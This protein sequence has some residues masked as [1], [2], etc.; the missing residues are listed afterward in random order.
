MPVLVFHSEIDAPE[1]WRQVLARA[2]P[3]L[4]FRIW[5]D[6]GPPAEVRYALVWK[7][8]HGMLASF[9]KLKAILSLGAGV[10][11][12]FLDA[13]LPRTV[14]ILR[15]VD[16][17]LRGQMTEY[18]LYAVLYFHRDMPHY[19]A[20][21]LAGRW[22]PLAAV[23]AA[24]RTVGVMGLGVLGADLA[25]MLVALGFRVLGWSRNGRALDGVEVHSGE[26]GLREMLSRSEILVNLLPLIPQTRNILNART[27]A[28]LPRG[29]AVINLARGGH[30]VEAD[31]LAALDSGHL[32]GAMLDVFEH[33]PLPEGHAFWRHPKVVFT[34]HISAQAVTALAEGQIVE[35]I[36]RME[37]GEAPIG[38]VDPDRGY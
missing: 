36:R 17:G 35:N 1:P 23:P 7:P 8:P 27:F 11:A 14:P 33:E 5:P 10:D 19:L 37:A 24:Q 29:A 12:L 18:G 22:A 38:L 3:D 34:P 28:Q 13:T 25:R 21:Q 9:P 4:E 32:R 15:L 20:A 6:V 30:L 31:L 2:C 16:A 26:G